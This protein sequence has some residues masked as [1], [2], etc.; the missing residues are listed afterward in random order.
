[1][2]T[3]E[4]TRRPP[5]TDAGPAEAVRVSVV[6]PCLNEADSIER[7]VRDALEALG[8]QDWQGEDDARR[9]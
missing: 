9:D 6:I 1:M 3:S 8:D 2:S 4:Q 7:C 5:V